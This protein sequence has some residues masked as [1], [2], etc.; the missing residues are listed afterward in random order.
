MFDATEDD[1]TLVVATDE[2]LGLEELGTDEL[3]TDELGAEELGLDE[4]GA[5]E[6]GFDELGADELGLDEL[7]TDE[8]DPVDK[9][10][11]SLP[12]SQTISSIAISKFDVGCGSRLAM[13][14]KAD[15]DCSATRFPRIADT[16]IVACAH[17]PLR[18]KP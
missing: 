14:N 6:L 2:E 15:I 5:D 16:G 11:A 8:D 4:L 3:G 12:H 1:E 17:S 9:Q 10:A 7:G 13:L 18:T